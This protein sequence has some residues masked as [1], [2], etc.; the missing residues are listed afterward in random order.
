[1][2]REAMRGKGMVAFAQVVKAR[3]SHHIRALGK[4]LMC[5]CCSNRERDTETQT[6]KALSVAS[7]GTN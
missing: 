1:V 3:T 2:I 4:R 6:W 7:S 5:T